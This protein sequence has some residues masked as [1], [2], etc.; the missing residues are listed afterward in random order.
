MAAEEPAFDEVPASETLLT[1]AQSVPERPWTPSY[2]VTQQGSLEPSEGEPEAA[3]APPSHQEMFTSEQ[4]DFVKPTVDISAL[5]APVDPPRASSPWTPSYSVSVQ[6]SP[7]PDAT[8]LLDADELVNEVQQPE[9]V[10]EQVQIADAAEAAAD[11]DP[12]A[13]RPTVDTSALEAPADPP[14]ASSPWTP[15]YSVS[16]QGSPLPGATKLLDADELVEEP[17]AA[18]EQVQIVDVA[19]PAV[20][21][22]PDVVQ[23]MVDTSALEAPVD[24]P[25]PSSPWTPSYSV[26]VQG[27]PLPVTTQLLDADKPVVD[28]DQS[29]AAAEEM[30]D[31]A[32]AAVDSVPDIVQPTVDT[33]ALE[34]PVEPPRPSSPWTP[35]YSVLVQGSPLPVATRLAD[36]AHDADDLVGDVQ[37]P[38]GAEQ[39]QTADVAE[40][41]VDPVPDV[42]Q[43]TMD[44]SALEAPVDA[45][46][47][48]S[49]WTVSYSVSVQGSPLPVAAQLVDSGLEADDLVGEIQPLDST[50]QTVEHAEVT[51][52]RIPDSTQ[53]VIQPTVDILDAPVDP[54]RASSP[55]TPSYSVSVQGSPLPA[56]TEL[57]VPVLEAEQ[58]LNTVEAAADPVPDLPPS[59][60][61]PTVEISALE[62]DA[63]LDPPRASSPWTPS[64][65][66]SVQG[67]PRPGATELLDAGLEADSLAAPVDQPEAAAERV[68]DIVDVEP[69]SDS[70]QSEVISSDFIPP[71]EATDESSSEPLADE[72]TLR[73][74]VVEEVIAE[75]IDQP[76]ESSATASDLDVNDSILSLDPTAEEPVVERSIPESEEIRA[77]T[78]PLKEP[79]VEDLE[80]IESNLEPA[81]SGEIL[82]ESRPPAEDVYS[83][84]ADPVSAEVSID[85]KTKQPSVVEEAVA[86]TQDTEEAPAIVDE[87]ANQVEDVAVSASGTEVIVPTGAT[88]AV[89]DADDLLNAAEGAAV[90]DSTSTAIDGVQSES[91]P[92]VEDNAVLSETTSL[93]PI[94]TIVEVTPNEEVVVQVDAAPAEEEHSDPPVTEAQELPQSHEEATDLPQADELV[95]SQDPVSESVPIE[96][97]SVKESIAIGVIEPAVFAATAAVVAN[98]IVDSVPV[99]ALEAHLVDNKDSDAVPD[100][101]WRAVAVEPKEAVAAQ[102]GSS[103]SAAATSDVGVEQDLASEA[104]A[105]NEKSPPAHESSAAGPEQD[106]SEIA[107]PVTGQDAAPV[108]DE[109]P[110]HPIDSIQD[111]VP[112][113]AVPVADEKSEHAEPDIWNM[114]DSA[115]ESADTPLPKIPADDE[116][117][118]VTEST[119][120]DTAPVLAQESEVEIESTEEP[121]KAEVANI[122]PEFIPTIVDDVVSGPTSVPNPEESSVADTAA[123]V[124]AAVDPTVLYA[125]AETELLQPPIADSESTTGLSAEVNATDTSTTMVEPVPVPSSVGATAVD[126]DSAPP[127]DVSIAQVDAEVANDETPVASVVPLPTESQPLAFPLMLD[128]SEPVDVSDDADESHLDAIP[129]LSPRSRLESTA[130]SIFFPGGWFSRVPEGRASLNVAQGEF[131]PSKPTSPSVPSPSVPSPSVPSAETEQSEEKKGKWCVVM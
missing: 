2:T 87:S 109:A 73:E 60:I 30:V 72:S 116:P 119:S 66:V 84:T 11:P 67:S 42:V 93:E 101:E 37:Q 5:D 29:A 14:R 77:T 120:L 128:L 53:S 99:Q 75:F 129:P 122:A 35:S 79:V 111:S 8:K 96:S 107:E 31:V 36:S 49:P 82:E 1:T 55:W 100:A 12:D 41:A 59:F 131:T 88:A 9:G 50:Q 104:V 123:E 85:S 57:V 114:A 16:V 102:G 105:V 4:D 80:T 126:E 19:E 61:P 20:D 113:V 47:P 118:V 90:A 26:S 95:P 48:S 121:F 76:A 62:V 24:A 13:V 92:E 117:A 18:A 110:T 46:R 17:E 7:L 83:A 6:G 91:A 71:L 28:I 81:E 10:A 39:V 98:E 65:S 15:S 51:A 68:V 78:E 108:V 89:S 21:P 103:L 112:A 45:P 38:E 63:P 94:A 34:A 97:D 130:S 70:V 3:P 32:E 64:Y 27:S 86:P 25:R 56:S 74:V 54:P 22:V 58:I 127:A 44:T 52:D 23:P 125:A 43:P 124:D 40:P 69:V 106:V 33:S 115:R